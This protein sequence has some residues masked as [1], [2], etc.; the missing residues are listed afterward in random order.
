MKYLFLL[1]TVVAL[2]A[3]GQLPYQSIVRIDPKRLFFREISLTYEV[4]IKGTFALEAGLGYRFNRPHAGPE[5]KGIGSGMFGG[6]DIQQMANPHLQAISMSVAPKWY[7][8]GKAMFLSTMLFSRYWWC[9]KVRASYDNVEGYRF[10]ALRTE[11]IGVIG[12]KLLVGTTSKP[13]DVLSRVNYL[14]TVYAGIGWRWKDM[15]YQSWDGQVND[16]PVVYLEEHYR[17]NI[18]SLHGG[19]LIGFGFHRKGGKL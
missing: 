6:Y 5:I 13:R 11:R 16:E 4:P 1:F 8:P 19:I 3:M 7:V 9:D 17:Q 15:R 10:D 12:G 2:P 18:P 14:M